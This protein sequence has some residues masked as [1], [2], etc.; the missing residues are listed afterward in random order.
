V[1][2]AAH[3]GHHDDQL[4]GDS[5]DEGGPGRVTAPM[6]FRAPRRLQEW[7]CRTG[8]E[9]CVMKL[10]VQQFLSLD[11][12]SQGPGAGLSVHVFESAGTPGFGTYGG[13]Q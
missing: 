5:G 1:N 11:G 10:V 4:Y 9:W 3:G 2:P 13:S 12:V 8:G 6:S 7:R